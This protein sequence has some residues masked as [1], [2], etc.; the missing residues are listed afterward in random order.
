M[1]SFPA[2][3]LVLGRVLRADG[4]P[5]DHGEPL[6][7]APRI[8]VSTATP[9]PRRTSAIFET[10]IKVVDFFCPLRAGGLH[11]I[12]AGYRL[13]KEVLLA[14]IVHNVQRYHAGRVVWIAPSQ[15]HA[16]GHHMVQSFRESGVLS[17]M[18]F[19]IAPSGQERQAMQAGLA[20]ARSFALA[21]Q[22]TVL[23]I[24]ADLLSPGAA[25]M[26]PQDDSVTRLIISHDNEVWRL[27]T[28][29]AADA[30]INFSP[31]LARQNI[32]PAVDGVHSASRLLEA[33]RISET[34]ARLA[35]EARTLIAQDASP[36]ARRL[37]LFGSQ[38]F[39]VAE[40]FTARPGVY[41]PLSDTVQG[42]AALLSGAYDDIPEKQL[43]FLGSLPPHP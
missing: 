25:A 9:A 17:A 7:H 39:A 23:G 4:V 43:A 18:S 42:Y 41:V 16:D 32:W 24:E 3:D 10:G 31:A 20:L 40:P 26:L 35:S 30:T 1:I 2:G 5:L 33:G 37:V 36:R 6:D 34:H 27:P 22:P 28:P 15:Q 21:G 8:T 12:S 14:E 38:P 11:Q 13:G 29:L 19:I